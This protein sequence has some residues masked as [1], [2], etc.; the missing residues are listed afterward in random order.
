[1]QSKQLRSFRIFIF[2][3][4]TIFFLDTAYAGGMMV[5]YQLCDNHTVSTE[6]YD[7]EGHDMIQHDHHKHDAG[8]KQSTNDQCSKCGHCMACFTIL[9]PSKL[10]NIQSQVQAIEASLLEPEY[11]SHV[12]AQPHRPP[13]S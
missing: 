11:L 12:G 3:L 6:S 2:L 7:H 4:L 5:A 9:P 10:A 1:M 8:Q 13:I